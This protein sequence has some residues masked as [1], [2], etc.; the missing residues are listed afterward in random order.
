MDH[1][2]AIQIKN[3]FFHLPLRIPFRIFARN[4]IIQ[5]LTDKILLIL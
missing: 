5:I 3:K 2:G 1:A 4:V